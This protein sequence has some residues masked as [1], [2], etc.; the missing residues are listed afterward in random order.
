MTNNLILGIIGERKNYGNWK[1]KTEDFS[2]LSVFYSYEGTNKKGE[3]ISVEIVAVDYTD[4][5]GSKTIKSFIKN[6]YLKKPLS[7]ALL[8][9]T[10][11]TDE[12]GNCR[13]LAYNPTV[14]RQ[15]KR[16]IINFDWFEEA[17]EENLYKLL[18]EIEKRFLAA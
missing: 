12:K 5:Y 9:R 13:G 18:N 6:G 8:A 14:K 11:T 2:S 3:T 10:Y 1:V 7:I 15:E 17:S 16:A 4:K